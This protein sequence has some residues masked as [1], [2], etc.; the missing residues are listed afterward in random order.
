MIDAETKTTDAR[1]VA[2]IPMRGDYSHI[3]EAMGRLY[4]WV[5]QHGFQPEGMPGAVYYT[6]P[7]DPEAPE[8]IWE[9]YTQLAGQ[10]DPAAV[11]EEGCGVKRLKPQLVAFAMHQGPF[12]TVASTYEIL[13]AW[14]PANGYAFAGPPEELYYS[15][16]ATTA[17][18]EYLTEIR[19][20]IAPA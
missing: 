16:P 10:P 2:Y 15:D 11:D 13:E 7:D 20:P 17:P 18:E 1:T 6:A 9:V 5:A 3:P 12:E 4:G 14:V 19:F 8:P